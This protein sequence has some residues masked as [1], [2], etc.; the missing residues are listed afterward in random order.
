[1]EERVSKEMKLSATKDIV[2][3]YIKASIKEGDRERPALSPDEVCELFKKVYN[4]ID[5]TIPS[6]EHRKVGLGL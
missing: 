5:E 2:S 1:M 4:T 6:A 3:S